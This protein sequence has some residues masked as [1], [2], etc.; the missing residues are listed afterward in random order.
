MLP[1]VGGCTFNEPVACSNAS[2]TKRWFSLKAC[3]TDPKAMNDTE[4]IRAASGVVTEK[5]A[6]Y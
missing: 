2:G 1:S 3:V 6:P 5:L 4:A